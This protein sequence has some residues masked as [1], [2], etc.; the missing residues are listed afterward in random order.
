MRLYRPASKDLLGFSRQT[1]IKRSFGFSGAIHSAMAFSALAYPNH[2]V[3]FWPVYDFQ[4]DLW[5]TMYGLLV[6]TLH[7]A[8]QGWRLGVSPVTVA[9]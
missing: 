6:F 9:Y 4:I 8:V 3:R 5:Y 7:G 1:V 2:A